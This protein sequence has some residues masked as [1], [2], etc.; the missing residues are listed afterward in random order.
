MALAD[1][2]L[3]NSDPAD[4][5]EWNSSAPAL[6]AELQ[7]RPD[8]SGERFG[9]LDRLRALHGEAG[10]NLR[11]ARFLARA[12]SGCVVL[13]L[14]GSLALLWAGADGGGALK[15][16]FAWAA[17]VLFGIVAMIRLHIRGFARSL[18]RTPLAEAAS[19]LRLLLLY[20]GMVWGGG[21]FLIMPDLPEPA[22]VFLFAAAPSLGLALSLKDRAGFAAFA[23]PASFLTAGASIL[24][25]W[26]LDLW[27]AGAI[28][29][30]NA[31]PGLAFWWHRSPLRQMLLRAPAHL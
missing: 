2:N 27:V 7:P 10:R 21:A 17:L 14:T 8:S 23:G 5:P 11:E 24:G 6:D 18:R 28:L 9:A 30:A 1:A 15:A 26:P 20:S 31:V 29:T 12:P 13:M 19:D 3:A 22:L 25:A 16:S 4:L